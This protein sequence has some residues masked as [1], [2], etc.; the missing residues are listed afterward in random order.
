MTV[1]DGVYSCSTLFS[2]LAKCDVIYLDVS[3]V[4]TLSH[5]SSYRNMACIKLLEKRCTT[6]R[7]NILRE[8][9]LI[10]F[11]S[12]LEGVCGEVPQDPQTQP[13]GGCSE[14]GTLF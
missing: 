10:A 1:S 6:D 7:K 9:L 14:S 2:D 8:L 4:L 3:K 11:F 5:M 12:N 13:T